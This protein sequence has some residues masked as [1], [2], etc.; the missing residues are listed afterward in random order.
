VEEPIALEAKRSLDL[1]SQ[2]VFEVG[3]ANTLKYENA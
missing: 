1:I 2:T 3:L